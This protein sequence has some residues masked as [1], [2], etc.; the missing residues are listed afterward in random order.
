[1]TRHAD[2]RAKSPDNKGELQGSFEG[3]L[4]GPNDEFSRWCSTHAAENCAVR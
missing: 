1:V 4:F 3:G 2:R